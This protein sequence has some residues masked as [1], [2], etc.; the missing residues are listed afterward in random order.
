MVIALLIDLRDY[1]AAKMCETRVDDVSG[2]CDDKRG[3][4]QL[5]I[6]LNLF[7][8]FAKIFTRN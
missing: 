5:R 6:Q 7:N 8:L 4:Y 2:L 3:Y 1:D